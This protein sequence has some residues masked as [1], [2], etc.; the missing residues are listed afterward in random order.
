MLRGPSPEDRPKGEAEKK[1]G[2][3]LPEYLLQVGFFDAL[4]RCHWAPKTSASVGSRK[5]EVYMCN[6]AMRAGLD[7]IGRAS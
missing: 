7:P 3:N 2:S 5:N 6:P 1:S 4:F